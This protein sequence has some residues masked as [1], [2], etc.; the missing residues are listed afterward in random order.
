MKSQLHESDPQHINLA[1]NLAQGNKILP[2][3][4][5]EGCAA[6]LAPNPPVVMPSFF[7]YSIFRGCKLIP[8]LLKHKG[9]NHICL[10][11]HMNL[12]QIT[13]WVLDWVH[14]IFYSGLNSLP[15]MKCQ[16]RIMLTWVKMTRFHSGMKL[17]MKLMFN[18]LWPKVL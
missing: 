5:N 18:K 3:A 1:N 14:P 13:D 7:S 4:P 11:V 6:L 16:F 9:L 17:G 15:R 10:L 12:D 8:F 2:M